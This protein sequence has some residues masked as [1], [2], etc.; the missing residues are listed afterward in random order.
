M[1]GITEPRIEQ[2][3]RI[4]IDFQHCE[5]ETKNFV[6]SQKTSN[7]VSALCCWIGIAM[8]DCTIA[9]LHNCAIALLINE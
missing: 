6:L 2:A 8:H 3:L 1:D 5:D 9:R 4:E 7:G